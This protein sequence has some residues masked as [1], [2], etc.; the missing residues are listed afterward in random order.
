MVTDS[1]H[2]PCQHDKSPIM[3]RGPFKWL[4]TPK[5]VLKT[6]ADKALEHQML[7]YSSS[8]LLE[9]V[10]KPALLKLVLNKLLVSCV[11][12]SQ[13]SCQIDTIKLC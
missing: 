7:P 12:L 4:E 6:V 5:F 9:M 1:Y 3:R 13:A 10:G 8:Q 11:T 2:N